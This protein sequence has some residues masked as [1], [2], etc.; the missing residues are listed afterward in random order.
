[1]AIVEEYFGDATE[2]AL[3]AKESMISREGADDKARLEQ[4]KTL[5][6]KLDVTDLDGDESVGSEWLGSISLTPQK[7]PNGTADQK[8]CKMD[9]DWGSAD[10]E[11]KGMAGPSTVDKDCKGLAAWYR[12]V[13]ILSD[14]KILICKFSSWSDS[15]TVEPESK[16]SRHS[17]FP[18][19]PFKTSDNQ[20]RSG[21]GSTG[22]CGSTTACPSFRF[23]S[24]MSRAP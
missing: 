17:P 8:L 2:D 5:R 4:F 1:M 21:S 11:G 23:N 7:E 12:N 19:V 22:V 16:E 24:G 18:R 10:R 13:S 6:G 3:S 20:L 9:S 14:S 15:G